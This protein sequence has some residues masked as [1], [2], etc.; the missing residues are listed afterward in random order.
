MPYV[1][2]PFVAEGS[3]E[4]YLGAISKV[5]ELHPRRLVHG[6]TPLGV[7]FT[8]EAMPGLNEAMRALYSRTLAAAYEAR[9]LGD[10]LADNFLPASLS[11]APAAAQP[12]IIV[13]DTFVQR[14]YLEH[15]GYWQSNGEGMDPFSRVE[16]AAAL[17]LLG[18]AREDAFVRAVSELEARGDAPMALHMAEFGLVR[19]P[20]SSALQQSRNKALTALRDIY[21]QTN[22]FRFIIYSEWAGGDMDPVTQPERQGPDD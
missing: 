9:P 20:S 5:L 4:G 7:L 6:H 2:A 15:A 22:P 21:S 8:T 17:D 1:G 11:T 3:P 18:G 19:Y 13:R 14:L 16:W 12:Y 10:V